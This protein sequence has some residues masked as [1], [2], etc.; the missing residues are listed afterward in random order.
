MPGRSPDVHAAAARRAGDHHP[1]PVRGLRALLLLLVS[2]ALPAY[3]ETWLWASGSTSALLPSGGFLDANYAAV[4]ELAHVNRSSV[5]GSESVPLV[6]AAGDIVRVHGQFEV[7]EST[8]SAGA[9]GCGP[10]P[11]YALLAYQRDEGPVTRFSAYAKQQ[12]ALRDNSRMPLSV[13][14]L[15]PITQAGA[16]RF[17]L[18]ARQTAPDQEVRVQREVYDGSLALEIYRATGSPD[19]N[20]QGLVQSLQ[21]SAEETNVSVPDCP[22]CPL[23]ALTPIG[24][25]VEFSLAPGDLAVVQGQFAALAGSDRAQAAHFLLAE[26]AAPDWTLAAY[27][28]P[29]EFVSSAVPRLSL[30]G[31]LSYRHADTSASNLRVRSLAQA[32]GGDYSVQAFTSRVGVLRFSRSGRL[33]PVDAKAA[34]TATETVYDVFPAGETPWRII[35]SQAWSGAIA[36]R[37]GDVLRLDGGI[38]LQFSATTTAT[39]RCRA[40]FYVVADSGPA[41][42]PGQNFDPLSEAIRGFSPITLRQV[43]GEHPVASLPLWANVNVNWSSA[44]TTGISVLNCDRIDAPSLVIP[45]D[46]AGLNALLYRPSDLIFANGFDRY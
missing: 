38:A 10:A 37:A 18:Q 30:Y 22:G 9:A 36:P 6:L 14:G 41:Y 1:R 3:A 35:Q 24:S 29:R 12:V 11:V 7:S 21:N 26:A 20:A 46:F 19:G 45:A 40:R 31:A 27:V 32:L 28:T 23:S 39:T 2:C 17:S 42:A 25:P 5:A 4:Y 34:T 33:F 8:C 44:A 13:D 15:L 43:S 16:Y